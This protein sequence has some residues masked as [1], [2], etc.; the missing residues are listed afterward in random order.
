MLYILVRNAWLSTGLGVT[1]APWD[2]KSNI[3]WYYTNAWF[4]WF[5]QWFWVHRAMYSSPNCIYQFFCICWIHCKVPKL[6]NRLPTSITGGEVCNL[7]YTSFQKW[8]VFAIYSWKTSVELSF[9]DLWV[10]SF[11]GFACYNVGI[12]LCQ[13]GIW[14]GHL[15]PEWVQW[16]QGSIDSEPLSTIWVITTTLGCTAITS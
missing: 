9:I 3:A 5:V 11:N 1:F 10:Y 13:S 8:L 4:V 2:Y 15:V 16:C 7:I 14:H 12:V 6:T